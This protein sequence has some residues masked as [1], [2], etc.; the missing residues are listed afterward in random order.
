MS[1]WT[2]IAALLV[3]AACTAPDAQVPPFA[4]EPYEAFSRSA[5]IAIATDQWRL[6]GSPVDDSMPGSRPPPKPWQ[7]PERQPGLWQ[8]VGLYWWLGMNAGTRFARWTG[9]HDAHGQVFPANKDS[10]FAWSAAFISYVM[11]IGGAGPAFPYSAAHAFYVDAGWHADHSQH[12]RYA[13]RAERTEDYAPVP[14]D[15]VCFGTGWA[16]SLRFHDLPVAFFPGHC[17][18]VTATSPG[19]I[20]VIGGNVDDAVTMKHVPTTMDGRLATPDGH[21]LDPRY[22]WFVVVRVLYAR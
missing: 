12:P 17:D 20:T 10:E 13:V 1:G 4:R 15:L 18:I 2:L 9:K 11:R 6:F 21:V 8:Q 14:G 22:P 5:A 7:K 16:R 19:R 3:L